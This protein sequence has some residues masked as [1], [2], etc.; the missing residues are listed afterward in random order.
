MKSGTSI[1][2]VESMFGLDVYVARPALKKVEVEEEGEAKGVIVMITDMFGWEL[3][4]ARLLA[5]AYANEGGWLVMVPDFMC[6]WFIIFPFF[7]LFLYSLFLVISLHFRLAAV[8]KRKMCISTSRYLWFLSGRMLLLFSPARMLTQML[9][10]VLTQEV[11][12][13]KAQV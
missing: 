5:D 1:G 9:T 2:K 12:I 6:G 8:K 4:N 7:A 3:S 13:C 10:Q 11:K